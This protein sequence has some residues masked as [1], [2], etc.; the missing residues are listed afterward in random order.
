M[1]RYG[2]VKVYP[3]QLNSG[4]QQDF[5]IK[6]GRPRNLLWS[7]EPVT[8]LMGLSGI[9]IPPSIEVSSC[10]LACYLYR[11][12]CFLMVLLIQSSQVIHLLYNVKEVSMAYV[13][14]L[15]SSALLCNFIIESFNLALYTVGSHI[16]LLL[17]TQSKTWTD[18]IDSFKRLDENLPNNN[19]FPS[20]R[21][22][23]IKIIIY[24]IISV[25]MFCN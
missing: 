25:C 6:T 23:A 7:L 20:C 3:N 9:P 21:K 22:L 24:I 2:L 15:S 1:F 8:R 5:V 18:L 17:L 14:G 11:I 4:S 19:L 10:R 12:F 13:S 16:C